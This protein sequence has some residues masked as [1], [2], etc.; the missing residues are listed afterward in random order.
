MKTATESTECTP[1]PTFPVI[2]TELR[3]NVLLL[4]NTP[5]IKVHEKGGDKRK[6]RTGEE[7]TRRGREH[8]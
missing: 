1:P 8:E 4:A 7:V 6:R 3:L 2:V 5:A